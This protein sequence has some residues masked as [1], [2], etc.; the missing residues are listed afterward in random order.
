[1]T[2]K[3]GTLAAFG[4]SKTIIYIGNVVEGLYIFFAT[5]NHDNQE[6]RMSIC[7]KCL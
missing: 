1:M 3:Q 5:K 7:L 6:F 2:K 4:F